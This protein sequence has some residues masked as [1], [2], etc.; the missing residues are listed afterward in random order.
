MYVI[1]KKE[2]NQMKINAKERKETTIV[3]ISPGQVFRFSNNIYM[4]VYDADTDIQCDDCG[5]RV[6]LDGG[7]LAVDLEDGGLYTFY[8]RETIEMID[9]EVYEK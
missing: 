9:C 2:G 5:E 8:G 1:K 3:S 6:E 7:Y 4:R